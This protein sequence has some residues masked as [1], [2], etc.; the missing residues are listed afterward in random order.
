MNIL[1]RYL[2]FVSNGSCFRELEENQQKVFENYF[3]RAAYLDWFEGDNGREFAQRLIESQNF[4][5]FCDNYFEKDFSNTQI[6]MNLNLNESDFEEA[7]LSEQNS[8]DDFQDR[9]A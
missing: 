3:D 2:R 5:S 6:H 1:D 7:R 4:V 9:I 8:R